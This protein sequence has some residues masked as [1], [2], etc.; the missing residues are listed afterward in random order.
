MMTNTVNST[1]NTEYVRDL[2][3]GHIAV[4]DLA[5]GD[6]VLSN[7]MKIVSENGLLLMNGNALQIIGTDSNGQEYVGIQLGYDT[8]SNPSLI[9]RNE[10]G[11]TIL[12]P[13]GITADA[14][15]D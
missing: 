12:T 10:D 3:A 2:V 7:S 8:T 1:V 15:A 4:S 6:I 9:L 5:A 14:V 11:A 13:E